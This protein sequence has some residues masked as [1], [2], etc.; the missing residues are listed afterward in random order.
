M[1]R[2]LIRDWGAKLG[3]VLLAAA[4]WFHAVTEHSYRRDLDVPL[5][6]E[7]PVAPAGEPS[8]VISSP[9]PALVRVAVFGVGKD[10]L[11]VSGEDFLL[12]VRAPLGK[13]G[14]RLNLRLEPAQVESHSELGLIVEEVI[15][16]RELTV[17][18]DH[19]GERRVAIRPR[20]SL[21]P[22]EFHAQVGPII[23]DPDSV[24]VSGPL[25]H[26]RDIDVIYTDSLFR[27]G[28]RDDVDLELAL[29]VPEGRLVKLRRDRVRVLIDV[30]ELAEY[31]LLNVPVRVLG[32]PRGAVAEPSRVT[33]H[34]RGG[35]DL[36]GSLEAERDIG[37]SVRYEA[38]TGDD[39]GQIEVPQGRLYEIRRITPARVTVVIR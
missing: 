18:L 38:A 8:I 39:G 15:A 19:K 26:L 33:V 27:D 5:I 1:H 4:L 22:A 34:V 17:I 20:I 3:A 10:L 32:G 6:V 35:A 29:Q 28:V 9:V 23:L 30:Q 11:R 14:R 12:R 37:L 36:I 2:W 25:S 24:D 31:D 13:P 21:R 16:P 7:D